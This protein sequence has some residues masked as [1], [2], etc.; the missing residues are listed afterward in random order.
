MKLQDYLKTLKDITIQYGRL[1]GLVQT[2]EV[3]SEPPPME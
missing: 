1:M 3:E 2:N